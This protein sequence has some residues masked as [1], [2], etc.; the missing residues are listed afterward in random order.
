MSEEQGQ[1]QE[2]NKG[3]GR[4]TETASSQMVWR[5][6][7]LPSGVVSVGSVTTPAECH[8]QQRPVMILLSYIASD[9]AHGEA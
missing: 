5:E 9:D 1:E 3:Q 6:A 8:G 2:Q 7:G 4:A